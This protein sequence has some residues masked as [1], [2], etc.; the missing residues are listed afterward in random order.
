MHQTDRNFKSCKKLD[1]M[2]TMGGGG[3]DGTEG[4]HHS[5]EYTIKG[6]SRVEPYLEKGSLVVRVFESGL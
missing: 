2:Q 3:S 5:P 1:C 6:L 4:Y